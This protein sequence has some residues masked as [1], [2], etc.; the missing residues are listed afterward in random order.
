VCERGHALLHQTSSLAA[1]GDL[2]LEPQFLVALGEGEDV[3]VR[4][5]GLVGFEQ[6]E[7]LD[8]AVTQLLR[9]AKEPELAKEGLTVTNF[10]LSMLQVDGVI[11]SFQGVSLHISGLVVVLA[12]VADG[13]LA[14]HVIGGVVGLATIYEL[15]DGFRPLHHPGLLVA[16]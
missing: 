4:R 2:Q 8:G 3:R 15:V 10:R 7:P 11:C 5:E 12:P 14:G 16:A 13:L 9:Q 1:L 6:P